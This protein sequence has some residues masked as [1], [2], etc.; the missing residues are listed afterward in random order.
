MG[1]KFFVDQCKQTMCSR[2]ARRKGR[3]VVISG[4]ENCLPDWVTFK[5][6]PRG[7]FNSQV[8]FPSEL[9]SFRSE[10]NFFDANPKSRLCC[11]CLRHYEGQ[12]A[13]SFCKK[14]LRAIN[15]R[16]MT[17]E[18]SVISEIDLRNPLICST[19]AFEHLL[20]LS[21]APKKSGHKQ[22]AWSFY[23]THNAWRMQ[24]TA[25]M[26]SESQPTVKAFEKKE[27]TCNQAGKQK[28]NY[29]LKQSVH[30]YISKP[31]TRRHCNANSFQI[32]LLF[33]GFC[34]WYRKEKETCC[35]PFLT[36]RGTSWM[37]LAFSVEYV[38]RVAWWST[39]FPCPFNI[40]Y[41]A[42]PR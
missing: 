33:M 5:N 14:A 26:N 13:H 12:L 32:T 34:V 28:F 2:R 39:N 37:S 9:I 11:L 15:Q 31:Q 42:Q 3:T 8:S 24:I 25:Q 16:F 17:K 22:R 7:S 21:F 29:W 40:W 6:I 1:A 36:L 19:V 27:I 30:A 20:R 4:D 23:R 35:Q 18:V 10:R 41:L 38:S